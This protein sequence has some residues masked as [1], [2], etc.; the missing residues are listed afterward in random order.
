METNVTKEERR[1]REDADDVNESAYAPRRPRVYA[2]GGGGN[3]DLASSSSGQHGQHQ[4]NDITIDIK[5]F[6]ELKEILGPKDHGSGLVSAC[7][8]WIPS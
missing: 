1:E 6:E 5:E 2:F 4:P 7:N 8:K 3:R